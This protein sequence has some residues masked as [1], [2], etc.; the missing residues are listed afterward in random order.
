VDAITRQIGI[1]LI[2]DDLFVRKGL[3]V[4]IEAE[5]ALSVAGETADYDEAMALAQSEDVDVLLVGF[6][7][8]RQGCL[9]LTEEVGRRDLGVS[10]IALERSDCNDEVLRLVQAG[11]DGYLRKTVSP[12]ELVE[13]VHVVA[14]GGHVLDP[15]ILDAVMRDYRM[16]CQRAST[17]R[18]RGLTKRQRQV[19]MPVA[20]GLSSREIA[21]ELSL[22]HKTVEVHRRRIMQKLGARKVTDLVRY[23][24]REGLIGLERPRDA[25]YALQSADTHHGEEPPCRTSAHQN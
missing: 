17:V 14:A 24:M 1:A 13:A 23:A 2:D 25:G 3:G 21:E 20:E 11:V 8:S 10:V 15:R 18:K 16:R 6:L 4:V 5:P 7:G 9:R 22:S 19:L 12:D